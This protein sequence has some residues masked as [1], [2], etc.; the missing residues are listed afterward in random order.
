MIYLG[1]FLFGWLACLLA[2]YWIKFFLLFTL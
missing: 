2:L 1:Y